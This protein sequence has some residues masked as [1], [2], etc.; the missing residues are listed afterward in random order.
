MRLLRERK[1]IYY[2]LIYYANNKHT[3]ADDTFKCYTVEYVYRVLN[4]IEFK[5]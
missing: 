4:S 2:I 1:R 3:T 5:Y